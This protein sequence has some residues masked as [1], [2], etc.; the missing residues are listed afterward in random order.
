M[1]W[2]TVCA[3][4]LFIYLFFK[5]CYHKADDYFQIQSIKNEPLFYK[6]DIQISTRILFLEFKLI[7]HLHLLILPYQ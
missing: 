3:C 4:Y 7:L 1:G 5:V 2:L 6:L